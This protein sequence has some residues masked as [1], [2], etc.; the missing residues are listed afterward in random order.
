MKNS[1]LIMTYDIEDIAELRV[2]MNFIFEYSAITS[3]C[4]K[5]AIYQIEHEKKKFVSTSGH[6]IFCLVYRHQWNTRK[7][8]ISWTNPLFSEPCRIKYQSYTQSYFIPEIEKISIIYLYYS[9]CYS[10]DE[11]KILLKSCIIVL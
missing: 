7:A 10:N 5:Q 1:L 9:E 4:S 3:E 8:I 6:V 11:Y 2:D